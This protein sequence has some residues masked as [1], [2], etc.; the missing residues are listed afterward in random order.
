MPKKKVGDINTY[1]ETHGKGPPLVMIMGL[2]AN[3]DWWP[4]DLIEQFSKHFKTLIFDSRG[5]GRTDKPAIDYSIKMFADDTLGLMDA[6]G[7][8]QAHILGVS[9]GG[10]IA[11][12]MALSYPQRIDKLVLVSTTCGGPKSVP[13]PPETVQ[14]VRSVMEATS[15]EL[16]KVLVYLLYPEEYRKNNP[17]FIEEQL[18]RV[19]IAPMPLDAYMRQLIAT[20]KFDSYDKLPKIKA[21]TIVLTGKKDVVDPWENSKMLAQRIP[22][23]KLVTFED[24]GHGMCSQ[25]AEDFAKE[26]IKFLKS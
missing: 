5:A 16:M 7:I 13:F 25:N 2:G 26:V 18:R 1:Y 24:S 3:K 19:M 8:K 17:E 12:E 23:A 15:E 21:P 22:G 4:P 6:L 9:M 14:K 11:Q 10:R 20:S